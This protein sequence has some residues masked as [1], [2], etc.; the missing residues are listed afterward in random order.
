MAETWPVGTWMGR[1]LPHPMGTPA[2]IAYPEKRMSP[3]ATRQSNASLGSLTFMM[4]SRLG[5]WTV[6]RPLGQGGMGQV[7]LAHDAESGNLA[8]IKILA[9]E[10]STEL[11]FLQRFQR[12]IEVLSTLDHANIVHFLESGAQDHTYYY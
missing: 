7:Y 2:R 5:R 6:D 4:G 8:A 3:P 10:L 12:E 11:G 9:A 1:A